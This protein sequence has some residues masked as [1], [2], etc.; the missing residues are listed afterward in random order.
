M[1]V[2]DTAFADFYLLTWVHIQN[3]GRKTRKIATQR[4]LVNYTNGYES[5][6]I[7]RDTVILQS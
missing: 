3:N 4:W 6:A 5:W 1:A 7:V 2:W